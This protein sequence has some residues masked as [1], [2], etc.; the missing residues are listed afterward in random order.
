MKT[1]F[2]FI[3]IGFLL[4]CAVPS[5]V[6]GSDVAQKQPL[7]PRLEKY[8]RK[9]YL[10][11]DGAHGNKSVNRFREI[12]HI[13]VTD[14]SPVASNG[15]GIEVSSFHGQRFMVRYSPGEIKGISAPQFSNPDLFKESEKTINDHFLK[16]NR[17]VNETLTPERLIKTEIGMFIFFRINSITEDPKNID[18]EHFWGAT[19]RTLS[20]FIIRSG[21]TIQAPDLLVEEMDF[22]TDYS[23]RD[24]WDVFRFDGRKYILINLI[25]YERRTFEIYETTSSKL[26]RVMEFEYGGL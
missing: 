26:N 23:N 12:G 8:V 15:E 7:K 9:N 5:R 13:P 24:L 3:S 16:T 22:E 14:F 20:S 1:L 10:Q 19:R 6:L 25:E 18:Y 2:A 21:K 17:Y 4:V 11:P